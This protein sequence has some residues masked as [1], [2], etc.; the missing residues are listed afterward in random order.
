MLR[1]RR[2]RDAIDHVGQLR[3]P[4]LNLSSVIGWKLGS[5]PFVKFF[6]STPEAI[7]KVPAR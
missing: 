6:D 7:A 4:V 5:R 1:G 3:N 2:S